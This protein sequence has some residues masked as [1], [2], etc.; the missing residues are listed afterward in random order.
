MTSTKTSALV[1][2]VERLRGE[3][4][5]ELALA[6]KTIS[7]QGDELER[8]TAQ[9]EELLEFLQTLPKCL[10]NMYPS[11]QPMISYGDRARR[12]LAAMRRTDAGAKTG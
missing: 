5:A 1:A 11:R 6:L 12:L 10:N 3:D 4:S 8:L 2:E 9:R 7:L